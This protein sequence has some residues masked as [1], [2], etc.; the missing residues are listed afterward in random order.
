MSEDI[1]MAPKK[2]GKDYYE[3]LDRAINNLIKLFDIDFK[4]LKKRINILE[5][6]EKDNV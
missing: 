6:K 2:F 4:L 1:L 5:E 3:L